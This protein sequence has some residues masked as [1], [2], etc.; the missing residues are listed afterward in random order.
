MNDGVGVTDGENDGEDVCDTVGEDENVGEA[1]AV[2]DAEGEGDAVGDAAAAAV[3]EEAPRRPTPS[4]MASTARAMMAAT[5]RLRVERRAALSAVAV[6]GAA[7]AAGAKG[8]TGAMG[9]RGVGA[10]MRIATDAIVAR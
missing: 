8:A 6:V 1:V 4:P 9:A 7:G 5:T 3:V 10:A 2:G